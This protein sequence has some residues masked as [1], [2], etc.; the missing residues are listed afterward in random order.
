MTASI[1]YVRRSNG[2]RF[3]SSR[4]TPELDAALGH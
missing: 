4:P 2:A 1:A 3:A